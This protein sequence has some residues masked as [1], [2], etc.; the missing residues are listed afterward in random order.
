MHTLSVDL[1][2]E[3]FRVFSYCEASLE[4]EEQYFWENKL[5]ANYFFLIVGLLQLERLTDLA[6]ENCLW[7]T[8]PRKSPPSSG[9]KSAT[10]SRSSNAIFSPGVTTDFEPSCS[11]VCFIM[12]SACLW[13]ASYSMPLSLQDTTLLSIRTRF[14][15]SYAGP[16]CLRMCSNALLI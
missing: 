12:S 8:M 3:R 15:S 13:S 6:P 2:N 10:S 4:G 16:I 14:R 11:F 7:Q 1:I 5:R 9:F